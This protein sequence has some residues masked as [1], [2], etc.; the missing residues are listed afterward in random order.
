MC[1]YIHN[2]ITLTPSFCGIQLYFARYLL[3]AAQLS[4]ANEHVQHTV[5]NVYVALHSTFHVQYTVCNVHV[6][7][8]ITCTMNVCKLFD[9]V[10][11]QKQ[12][13]KYY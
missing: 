1:R 5:C 11:L 12:H 2:Y 3:L 13:K 9:I 7:L 8:Y 6:A 4:P 10:T